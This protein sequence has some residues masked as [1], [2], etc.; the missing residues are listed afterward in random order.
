MA[1]HSFMGVCCRLTHI[2]C[3]YFKS[4][5]S[6]NRIFLHN[7]LDFHMPAIRLHNRRK[8][9]SKLS[10]ATY[11]HH[12]PESRKKHLQHENAERTVGRKNSG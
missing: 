10:S 11:V 1:F 7:Q 8:P 9:S 4:R 5:P 12:A 2:E 6:T 3:I